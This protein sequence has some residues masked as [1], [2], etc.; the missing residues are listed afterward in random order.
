MQI[1][2][3]FNNNVSLVVDGEAEKI[4]MGKGVGFQKKTGDEVDAEL[5]EKTFVLSSGNHQSEKLSAFFDEVPLHIVSLT[6]DLIQKGKQRLGEHIGDHLLVPLADHI[7][8][9]IERLNEGMEMDYPLKWEMKHLYAEEYQFAKGA[10]DRIKSVTGQPLPDSEVVPIAMHFVN[11][12]YGATDYHQTYEMTAIVS[13][14]I[15]VV[16][17]HYFIDLDEDSLHYARFITHLRY[18]VLRQMSGDAHIPTDTGISGMLQEK[19]P[20]A[21]ECALKIKKLLESQMGWVVDNDEVTY[22]TIHIQ[23]LTYQTE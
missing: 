8:F 11:A 15:D 13:K 17:Y 10:L 20:K 5:I 16:H 1:K 9:A 7:W 6:S 14:V 2:K 22:L 21:Y 12:R 3:V 4:I 23:R 19:Y 18:F